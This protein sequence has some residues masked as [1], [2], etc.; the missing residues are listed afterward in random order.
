MTAVPAAP[1]PM[2]ATL[3]YPKLSRQQ[4][5]AVFLIVI[6]PEA[7]ADVLRQFAWGVPAFVLA[8]VLTPPFFA[9]QDTRRPMIFSVASVG[10]TV[11]LGSALF[12]GLQAA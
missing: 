6:G 1:A 7:A 12:F 5:L 9:R 10:V 3:D 2:S 11:A 4:K 8:K